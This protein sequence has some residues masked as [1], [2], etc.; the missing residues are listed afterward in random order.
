M[1]SITKS[2]PHSPLDLSKPPS[3]GGFDFFEWC[4]RQ[5]NIQIAP[6]FAIIFSPMSEFPF[7]KAVLKDCGGDLSKRWYL[8]FYVWSERKA[9]L[10]RRRWYKGFENFDNY[11]DRR[12]YGLECA[13]RL[14]GV[15][16]KSSVDKLPKEVEEVSMKASIVLFY[17]SM[18]AVLKSNYEEGS[19]TFR[20]YSG[21]LE[22]FQRFLKS[23]GLSRVKYDDLQKGHVHLYIDFLRSNGKSGATVRNKIAR[24]KA[25]ASKLLERELVEKNI[26]IGLKLPKVVQTEKNT[27]FSPDLLNK[28]KKDLLKNDP[29]FWLCCQFIYYTYMRPAEIRRLKVKDL[30]LE[31]AKI[32]VPGSISKNSKTQTIEIPSILL[33]QLKTNIAS[34]DRDFYLFSREE[35]PDPQQI[36][37]KFLGNKFR[38]MRQ[39]I[40]FDPKH[41]LYS[42]KHTGVVNAYKNGVD[43]K[44]IQQQCRH[45]SVVQ[46]D[47]YLK[48]LGFMDN[49]EFL[50]GMPEI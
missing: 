41:T 36:S 43:I 49:E 26:F 15:L 46:T 33:D 31:S 25:L 3:N 8:E 23:E 21:T 5:I 7:K 9:K 37:T 18:E 1:K 16:P 47:T 4:L 30:D 44:A 13:R 10:V 38:D 42:F 50:K 2:F 35:R 20:D 28:I 17:D 14:N 39:R 11:K 48:S 6:T 45:H 12:S 27:S 34:S 22:E 32:H 29:Y 24:L 40:G 19:K